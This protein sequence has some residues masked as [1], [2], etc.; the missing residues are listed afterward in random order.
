MVDL[1]SGTDLIGVSSRLQ[2]GGFWT[3]KID[4][5]LWEVVR[6]WSGLSHF[7]VSGGTTRQHMFASSLL[8]HGAT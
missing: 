5:S 8:M 1:L 3:I 4:P 6:M 2:R 7:L